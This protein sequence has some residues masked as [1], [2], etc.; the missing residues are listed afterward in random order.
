MEAI[1][2]TIESVLRALAAKKKNKPQ[3]TPQ[4]WLK[5]VLTK[6]ESGHI[7][8]SYLRGG[9]LGLAVDSSTR[10]YQLNLKKQDLLLRVQKKDG[11]IKD[12]RFHLGEMG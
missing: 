12:V 7:Q 5:K 2:D 10:L 4:D 1:K 6:R 11:T 9:V 3:A 8:F